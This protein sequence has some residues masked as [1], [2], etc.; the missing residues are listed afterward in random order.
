[1]DERAPQGVIALLFT[2][3]EGSTRVATA[4]GDRWSA[5]LAD[6]H[7][8][9][10]GAI[11]AEGGFVD[12]APAAAPPRTR[13]SGS[14]RPWLPERTKRRRLRGSATWVARDASLSSAATA[15]VTV[16]R[17]DAPRFGR[18]SAVVRP[19]DAGD[20]CRILADRQSGRGPSRVV[21]LLLR[22]SRL[23]EAV[24]TRSNE[25]SES[26]TGGRGGSSGRR[27]LKPC[28]TSTRSSCPT[29]T[30]SWRLQ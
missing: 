22:S 1:M 16:G 14:G 17:A 7:A 6:H 5:A 21:R 2:D 8:L 30:R 27:S 11:V 18:R 25:R 10:D 15:S 20:R 28:P 19:D 13:A 12:N 3:V 29:S 4:L 23:V 24:A 9:V 26:S